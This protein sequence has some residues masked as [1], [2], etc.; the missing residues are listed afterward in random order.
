MS[1]T[2]SIVIVSGGIRKLPQMDSLI[3]ICVSNGGERSSQA[4]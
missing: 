1:P 3:E 2:V 4:R